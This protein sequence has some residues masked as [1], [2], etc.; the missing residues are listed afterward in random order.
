M[1]E[2]TSMNLTVVSYLMFQPVIQSS[3]PNLG[4]SFDLGLEM[5]SQRYQLNA[6][7]HYIGSPLVNTTSGMIENLYLISNFYYTQWDKNGVLVLVCPGE[8]GHHSSFWK[9]GDLSQKYI[10]KRRQACRNLSGC[11]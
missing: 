5:L 1:A 10:K 4:A 7:L 2:R 8:L 6:T 9:Y 11:Q 3:R